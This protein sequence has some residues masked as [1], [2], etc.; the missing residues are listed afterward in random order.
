[1]NSYVGKIVE[2]FETLTMIELAFPGC[3]NSTVKRYGDPDRVVWALT[4][5]PTQ[6]WNAIVRIQRYMLR[7]YTRDHHDFQIDVYT[8]LGQL[9]ESTVGLRWDAGARPVA[10]FFRD[11]HEY[12]VPHGF[13]YS[14]TQGRTYGEKYLDQVGSFLRQ[15]GYRDTKHVPRRNSVEKIIKRG[16][17][18]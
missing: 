13:A 16:I 3:I 1:M 9:S 15:W 7:C 17:L 4:H 8:P 18:G 14:D 10:K 6:P 2:G 5:S 12:L 11:T